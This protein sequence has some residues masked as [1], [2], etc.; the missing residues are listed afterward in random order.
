MACACVYLLITATNKHL[1]ICE[2]GAFYLSGYILAAVQLHVRLRS[3]NKWCS[4]LPPCCTTGRKSKLEW[5][6]WLWST[7]W[8][9]CS[10]TRTMQCP[11]GPATTGYL[12]FNVHP[13]IAVGLHISPSSGSVKC[14]VSRQTENPVNITSV[15]RLGKKNNEKKNSPGCEHSY[16]LVTSYACISYWKHWG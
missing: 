9:G 1:T 4:L 12:L 13:V 7:S 11:V 14:K 8:S 2:L 16:V 6:W 15:N 5:S 3:W 10:G